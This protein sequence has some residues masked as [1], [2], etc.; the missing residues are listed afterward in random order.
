MQLYCPILLACP[1]L[2]LYLFIIGGF[3]IAS[4]G[5]LPLGLAEPCS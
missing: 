2:C 1:F 5:G 3:I 4:N